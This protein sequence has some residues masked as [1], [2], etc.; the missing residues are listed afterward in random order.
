[1]GDKIYLDKNALKVLASD[2]RVN[3]LKRLDERRRTVTELSR[4]LNL[5]KAT[6]HEHLSKLSGAGLIMRNNEMQHKWVYYEL[7][8][9][10]REIL[11]PH[12][13]TKIRILLASASLAFAGGILGI[14]RFIQGISIIPELPGV[15]PSAVQ[16]Q[17]VHEPAY[18]IVGLAL[19]SVGALLP[20]LA[21][22]IQRGRTHP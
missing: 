9:K 1:V 13:T 12:E 16:P 10:G 22:R 5:A 7:T 6:V 11:H 3:I 2:T 4:E 18:L 20:Y 17:I 14:Y 19:I 15:P 21:L 8:R